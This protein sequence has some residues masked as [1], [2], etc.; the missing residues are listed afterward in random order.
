[1]FSGPIP[2]PE[3]FK[4]YEEVLPGS[5]DRILVMSEN[6]SIHRIKMESRVITFDTWRSMLGLVFAFLLVA[7][8]IIGGIYLIK[9]DKDAIGITTMFGPLATVILAFIYQQKAQGE[10]NLRTK[11]TS[12][13]KKK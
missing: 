9:H 6:Q 5:A 4:Q 7:G 8:G 2:P 10:D 11:K 12:K 13:Y 3:L 1:M